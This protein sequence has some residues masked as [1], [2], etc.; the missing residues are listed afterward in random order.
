MKS[1]LKYFLIGVIIIF[2]SFLASK[3][4]FKPGYFP[5]HDDMQAMRVLQ[6]DKCV[7]DGQIPCRWVPDMGYGF[8]YPQ[9]IYYSPLPYYVMEIFHLGGFG[10]LDSVKTGFV[11]SILF[12]GLTMFLLGRE[13]W[14]NLGGVVSA[15]FYIFIPYRA[16]DLFVRGA[17]GEFWAM[18]FFPLIFWAI[19]KLA[20]GGNS[21]YVIFLSLSIAGLLIT[22]NISTLMLLPFAF[23]WTLLVLRAEKNWNALR[24]IFLGVFGGILL[25]GFFVIPLVFEKK[26][27]HVETMLMGYFNYL[28]HFASLRQMLF[29]T[30]WG[31][32]SSELGPF[33][34]I[35]LSVGPLHWIIALLAVI[36]LLVKKSK[37]RLFGLFFILTAF[38]SLFLA[39]Q[40]SSFIWRVLPFMSYFQFPW[41]FLS[42]A[43]FA[44]SAVAGAFFLHSK[45]NKI[46]L[47]LILIFSAIYLNVSFFRTSDW[48]NISDEQKFSGTS[49][50]KQL[51][52]SIFDY[53]PI[54][55][56]MPPIEKAPEQ[57]IVIFG[58]AEILSYQKGTDWQ[59]G[60]I[61]SNSAETEVRLPLF[62]F[63]GFSVFIDGKK[64]PISYNNELGLI[65]VKIPQGD[66]ELSVKLLKTPDRW[67]GDLMSL[68][69]VILIG[70]L[71]IYERKSQKRV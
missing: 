22:H 27:A 2:A 33:D 29:S 55:A 32:G 59:K 9:F 3:D 26:Y 1:N 70:A 16:S 37:K 17:V 31:F 51:T 34:D 58:S 28:Q 41:R 50:E 18:V 48:F 13:L 62:Y 24:K 21:K 4:L 53:L 52:I 56:K 44:F 68:L 25:A 65:D 8:G 63:P 7:K 38:F 46:F 39:H 5:M 15:V 20:K 61:Q 60:V 10:I 11:L 35:S 43:G 45:M 40:R 69:G 30:H 67:A 49:W 19:L 47:C 12:S 42:I 54:F 14:G 66:H 64:V 57:P 71:V 36:F 6:M 23:I